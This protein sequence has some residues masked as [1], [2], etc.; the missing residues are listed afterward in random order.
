M[1]PP[2]PST[3]LCLPKKNYILIPSPYICVEYSC[4][5]NELLGPPCVIGVLCPKS[6]WYNLSVLEVSGTE[7]S[8]L[9]K[10]ICKCQIRPSKYHQNVLST[11]S[12]ISSQSIKAYVLLNISK[13]HDEMSHDSL[14]GKAPPWLRQV[15]S[16]DAKGKSPKDW[17]PLS[18]ALN[19][20]V[21]IFEM[22]STRVKTGSALNEIS[23][24]SLQMRKCGGKPV[25][26]CWCIS[27]CTPQQ[28]AS[29]Q[30]YAFPHQTDLLAAFIISFHCKTHLEKV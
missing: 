22:T 7:V 30:P 14:Q 13:A 29:S 4:K 6:I 8:S 20:R 1:R 16:R 3:V 21:P 17:R 19:S 26:A 12:E 9:D 10:H 18:K 28:E 27:L 5:S 24:G 2:P 11:H 23:T 15:R 25:T